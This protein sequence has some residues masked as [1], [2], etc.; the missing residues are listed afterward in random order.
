LAELG[1]ISDYRHNPD[2]VELHDVIRSYLREQSKTR[3]AELHR[4]LVDAQR[5]L[6]LE[7]G[8]INVWWQLPTAE[9]YLGCGCPL[10]YAVLD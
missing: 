5:G 4:A 6:V 9:T 7:E 1:L 3:R 8:G 2:R 10:T